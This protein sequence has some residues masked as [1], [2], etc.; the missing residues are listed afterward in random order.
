M[1]AN[2]LMRSMRFQD[3]D[4]ALLVGGNWEDGRPTYWH[5]ERSLITIGPSGCGKTRGHVFPNLAR[6]PG[7]AFVLDIKGE[8]FAETAHVRERKFGPVFRFDPWDPKNSAKY[9]PLASVRTQK[10]DI[11]EDS[12][13]VAES[14]VPESAETE[15]RHFVDRARNLVTLCVAYT[16]FEAKENNQIPTLLQ[17]IEYAASFGTTDE[18][19]NPEVDSLPLEDLGIPKDDRP[20]DYPDFPPEFKVAAN[21]FQRSF[22]KQ[23]EMNKELQSVASTADGALNKVLGGRI[24]HVL[25]GSDWTPQDLRTPGTTVYICVPVDEVRKLAPVLRLIIGQHVSALMGRENETRSG[26][27]PPEILFF[28]DEIAQLGRMDPVLTALEVGRSSGLRLW[29]LVQ[30]MAQLRNPRAYGNEGAETILS[31]CALKMFMNPDPVSAIELSNWI[32][33]NDDAFT[34]QSKPKVK[35]QELFGDAWA[36]R[37]LAFASGENTH[38][39]RKLMWRG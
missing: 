13:L 8:C 29:L 31:N 32:G 34:G 11:W 23:G 37:V 10:F 1:G 30:S 36:D 26:Q 24:Q 22:S 21:Q 33:Q 16:C 35:P 39:F 18:H 17:A 14:L 9:N 38:R 28:L 15:N 19:G 27:R 3:S 12:R 4:T 5:D 6:W 2:L 25:S 20:A 7:S